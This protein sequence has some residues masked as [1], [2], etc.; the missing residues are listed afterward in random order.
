MEL[1]TSVLFLGL[2]QSHVA[3]REWKGKGCILKTYCCLL[4]WFCC[5]FCLFV[6]APALKCVLN[7]EF[8][9]DFAQVLTTWLFS[10]MMRLCMYL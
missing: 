7:D 5:V 3:D 10:N 1:L 9:V 8:S 4:L 2:Q 6:L